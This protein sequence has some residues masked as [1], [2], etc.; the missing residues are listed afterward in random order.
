[1]AQEIILLG[2]IFAEELLDPGDEWS[3]RAVK[4]G[5]HSVKVTRRNFAWGRETTGTAHFSCI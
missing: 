3:G 4:T 1:M 2:Q 5:F